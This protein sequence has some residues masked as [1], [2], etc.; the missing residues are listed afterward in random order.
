VNATRT[1]VELARGADAAEIA[2]LSRKYIEYNLGWQYRPFRIRDSIRNKSKNV[3]VAR[4]GATLAGF[5]IMTYLVDSA[6]LDLL[7]VKTHYRRR[8]VG[9]Q[10]VG[11]LETVART[12]GI[13]NVFV[14]VR[15]TNRGA[16][17]FY[18]RLGFRIVDEAAGYYQGREAA[19]TMCK[20]SF[21][22]G[23]LV[24]HGQSDEWR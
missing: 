7:A 24:I 21:S 1:N 19:V 5:G 23:S 14:Q 2:A 13:A 12:A 20:S 10:I 9:R 3:V 6:N 22:L 17:R 18:Q 16:I 11:W 15:K 4:A 8:G